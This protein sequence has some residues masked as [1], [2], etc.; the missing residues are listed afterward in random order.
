M[1]FNMQATA[2]R[3]PPGNVLRLL[4]VDDSRLAL[5]ASAHILCRHGYEVIATDIVAEALQAHQEYVMDAVVTGYEMPGM[6]G[7]SFAALVKSSP[8][9]PPILLHSACESIP[10][11]V[12]PFIDAFIPKGQPVKKFLNAI[13]LLLARRLPPAIS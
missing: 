8:S 2:K 11:S 1:I 6:S 3:G 13:D 9:S 10:L 4:C 7:S 5:L 12:S